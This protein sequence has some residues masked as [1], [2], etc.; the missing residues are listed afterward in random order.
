MLRMLGL[1]LYSVVALLI[2]FAQPASPEPGK[3]YIINF[4]SDFANNQLAAT[5]NESNVI[6]TSF[7]DGVGLANQQVS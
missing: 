5:F 7:H 1:I 6:V 3:Y 2:Q 4:S